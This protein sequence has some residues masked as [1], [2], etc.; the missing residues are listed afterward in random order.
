[1][2]TR[3]TEAGAETVMRLAARGYE[4]VV[5]PLLDI[6]MLPVCLPPAAELQ[7][8]LVTSAQALP[9]LGPAYRHVTLLAVGDATAALARQAG[10]TDV[11]S[12]EGDAGDLRALTEAQCRPELGTLLLLSGR[13]AAPAG[14]AAETPSAWLAAQLAMRF[15]VVQHV[16]YLTTPATKLPAAAAAA[17]QASGDALGADPGLR[18]EADQPAPA[19]VAALF[20]SGATAKV[21]VT[22]AEAA[23]LRDT[24]SRVEALAIS[25]ATA[26]A[27]SPLPWRAVRVASRPNQDELLALL[28]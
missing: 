17:L 1:L 8:V 16:V 7:A 2:V 22:L 24:V 6:Q 13:S 26:R 15:R 11:R 10:H 9:A 12:A 3:P 18:I 27:L 21:F 28:R 4:A 20:F 14:A 25:A 19:L 23:G 5:A